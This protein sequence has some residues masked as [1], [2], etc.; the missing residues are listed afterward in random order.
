[1]ISTYLYTVFTATASSSIPT[2]DS[3]QTHDNFPL[4]VHL[5]NKLSVFP[6]TE[7]VYSILHFSLSYVQFANSYVVPTN[8]ANCSYST[9]AQLQCSCSGAWEPG[10]EATRPHFLTCIQSNSR[11]LN[12]GIYNQFCAVKK[13]SW[14]SQTT[15]IFLHAKLKHENFIARKFPDLRQQIYEVGKHGQNPGPF[16]L[17]CI[18]GCTID[19][20]N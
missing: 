2:G 9:P 8:T 1:M 10:N 12:L 4:S 18:P 14:V 3:W 11:S 20:D 19:T 7:R 15:K 6:A 13:F 5:A 17:S 16:H